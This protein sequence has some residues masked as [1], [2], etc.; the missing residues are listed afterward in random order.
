MFSVSISQVNHPVSLIKTPAAEVLAKLL[1]EY[2][3]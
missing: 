2:Q 3:N 1:L